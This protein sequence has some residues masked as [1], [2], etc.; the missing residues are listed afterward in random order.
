LPRQSRD[1]KPHPPSEIKN[2]VNAARRELERCHDKVGYEL[3]ISCGE[4]LYGD[5]REKTFHQLDLFF[6][7]AE[8]QPATI[9]NF[10]HLVRQNTPS[11][12]FRGHLDLYMEMIAVDACRIFADQLVEI[13]RKHEGHLKQDGVEWAKSQDR[14]LIRE[15]AHLLLNWVRMICDRPADSPAIDAQQE[16]NRQTAWQGP[17]WLAMWPARHEP[18]DPDREWERMD[19]A[20]SA[21][22]LAGFADEYVKR[23]DYYIEDAARAAYLDIAKHSTVPA[24]VIDALP[25]TPLAPKEPQRRALSPADRAALRET[26]MNAGPDE[27]IRKEHVA[28]AWHIRLS[29]VKQLIEDGKFESTR[30]R[31]MLIAGSVQK[32]A[33]E[34]PG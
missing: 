25:V 23:L 1:N 29:R 18:Y 3:R 26:I 11:S 24:P 16:A 14:R 13:G 8:Q 2:A 33:K 19:A 20:R 28:N 5:Y 22:V 12:I 7:F 15:C 17:A 6:T 31:G 4:H 32:W 10:H 34:Q 27:W 9:S 30:I 21:R